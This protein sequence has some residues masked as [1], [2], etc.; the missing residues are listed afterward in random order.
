M[1]QKIGEENAEKLRKYLDSVDA[2]P[3]RQGKPNLTAIARAAG[4]KDR[5]PLYDNEKC[6]ELL[7]KAIKDKGLREIE[8]AAEHDHEK[9]VLERKITELQNK[10]DALYAEVHELR[11]QIQKYKHIEEMYAQGKRVI[12]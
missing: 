11:R 3:A 7:D 1:S 6:K 9:A 8:V 10:N 12:L 4:L 5:Q 2:L